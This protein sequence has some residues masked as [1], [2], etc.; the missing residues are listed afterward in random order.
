MVWLYFTK[1]SG[2]A[3][4]AG[5]DEIEATQSDRAAAIVAGSFLE[6]HLTTRIQ[7]R[8]HKNAKITKALFRPSGPLGAF[9]TKIDLGFLMGIIPNKQGGNS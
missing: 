2:D 3:F 8:M 7:L 6:E 5:I 1:A 9:A 4:R